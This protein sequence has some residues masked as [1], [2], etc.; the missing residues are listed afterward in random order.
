ME[1]VIAIIGSGILTKLIDVLIDALKK[2]K[3][4]ITREEFEQIIKSIEVLKVGTRMT[5]LGELKKYGNELCE[6]G[7]VTE[8]QLNAFEEGYKAYKD[9]GGDGFADR[10]H[11][12]VQGLRIEL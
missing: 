12:D 11:S 10:I 4:A 3:S 5:L 8:L 2:K 9:L 7:I 6:A 1:I